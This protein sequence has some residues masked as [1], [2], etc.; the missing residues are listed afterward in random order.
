MPRVV[1][2]LIYYN[3]NFKGGSSPFFSSAADKQMEEHQNDS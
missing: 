1:L 3:S 2:H